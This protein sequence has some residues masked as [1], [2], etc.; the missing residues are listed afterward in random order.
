MTPEPLIRLAVGMLALGLGTAC[1]GAL[2]ALALLWHW[3]LSHGKPNA[4][5][6]RA[7][8]SGDR[9]TPDE[10]GKHRMHPSDP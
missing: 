7:E 4:T 6:H 1:A 3:R 9:S 2:G 5:D 10:Q 8:G